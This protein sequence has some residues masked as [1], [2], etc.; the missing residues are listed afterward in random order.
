MPAPHNDSIGSCNL[1]HA[2]HLSCNSV[3]VLLKTCYHD[4]G[5][6]FAQPCSATAMLCVRNVVRS[7][8][9]EWHMS[10]NNVTVLL[11]TCYHDCGGGF[12]Q[13]CSV[14]AMLRVRN[15]VRPHATEWHTRHASE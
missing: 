2:W 5:C 10:C 4:C 12:A 11:K 8:A 7:H 3:K 9:T 13:A 1:L 14:A 15:V 6:G